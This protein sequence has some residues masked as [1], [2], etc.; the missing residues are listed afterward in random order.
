MMNQLFVNE[1]QC[2]LSCRNCT[3]TTITTAKRITWNH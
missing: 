2:R 1:L 3:Y